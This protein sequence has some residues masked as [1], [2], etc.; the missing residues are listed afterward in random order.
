M[1]D[2]D[3][4]EAMA[5]ARDVLGKLTPSTART[6]EIASTLRHAARL[7]TTAVA[8]NFSSDAARGLNN[9]RDDASTALGVV[10]GSLDARTLTQDMIDK[11][12]HAVAALLASLDQ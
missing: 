12:K 4:R 9:T 5:K 6:D 11:A 3:E 1:S 7:A 10:A 8:R 2:D